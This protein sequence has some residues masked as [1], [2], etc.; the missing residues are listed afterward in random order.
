MSVGAVM[1]AVLKEGEMCLEKRR[2]TCMSVLVYECFNVVTHGFLCSSLF[3]EIMVK[4]LNCSLF[5]H[6]IYQSNC[7]LIV[8]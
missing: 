4:S 8:Q 1:S 7:Y 2:N 5:G 6:L 3:E